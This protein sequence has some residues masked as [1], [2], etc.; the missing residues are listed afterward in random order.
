M[1]PARLHWLAAAL[2]PCT[3]HCGG[4]DGEPATA[5]GD[6]ESADGAPAALE[7]VHRIGRFDGD[8]RFAWPGS[9]IA[10]RFEGTAIS[11]RLDDG[12]QDWFSIEIDGQ[13][14]PPLQTAA[15]ENDYLLAGD[16]AGGEHELL[17]TRRTESFFGPSRFLGLSGAALVPTVPPDRL[18][19]FIGD[20]ITCGY[21]VLGQGPGCSFS[22]DTESETDAWGALTAR[23]LGAAHTAIAYSGKGVVR[24]FGGDTSATMPV[25]FG[26]TFADDAASAW[27]FSFAPDV[28]V[29]NLGTNDFSTGDP[30][31]AFEDGL[32]AFVED[33][34]GRYPGAP[35]LLATSPMLGG[36]AHAQHRAHLQA[37]VDAAGDGVRLVDIAEQ[38]PDD[39]LGCDFHPGPVTQQKM[40]DAL[41]PVIQEV[42]GWSAR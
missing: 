31:T 10:A 1:R 2:L 39:G 40:A 42:T 27:D 23:A 22:A 4:G 8:D 37:V 7:D 6:A 20:S 28:V 41:V 24:N 29:I 5:Q 26:R 19:E 25:L 21:G 34:R 13:A 16:L 38:D 17:L 30:G 33:I 12:G 35:I 36:D 9:A 3:I 15:G 14:R 11:A 18:I 32:L